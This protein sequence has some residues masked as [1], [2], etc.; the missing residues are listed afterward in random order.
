LHLSRAGLPQVTK[1]HQDLEEQIHSN[2]QLLAEN[3]QKQVELKLKEEEIAGIK[4]EAVRVNKLREATLNKLKLLEK[5]KAEVEKQR[6]D[7][8]A[9]IMVSRPT[10]GKA[11]SGTYAPLDRLSLIPR[12]WSI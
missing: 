2:T 11:G 6:D 4:Q 9:E 7:V 5:Q 1:L 8:R 3:S 10:G 12:S